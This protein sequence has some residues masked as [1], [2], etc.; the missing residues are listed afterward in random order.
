MNNVTIIDSGICNID[1]IR[2]AV[3]ECGGRANVTNN[4]ST[5]GSSDR[6]ILPGVGSFPDAVRALRSRDLDRAI[7]EEVMNFSLPFLGICLGMQL[8]ASIGE[9]GEIIDGFNWIPGNVRRLEKREESERVPHVGWN[10][11]YPTRESPLFSGIPDGSDFYFTH[12]YHFE[13]AD[14][15]HVL[16]TTPYC[17]TFTSAIE[18]GPILGVQFHPEKSQKY[19]MKLLSN[20]L[21]V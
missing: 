15:S 4:P 13:C 20:F 17:G 3:E 19:G 7:A 6:I 18:K 12:S 2:R 14:S 5:L 1:S 16:A 21:L 11:V 8:L 9:E 10:E